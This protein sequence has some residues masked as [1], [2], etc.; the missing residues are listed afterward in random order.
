LALKQEVGFFLH[1]P[2]FLF[3]TLS[4]T[5]DQRA[6]SAWEWVMKWPG[7]VN[8]GV[9]F[10]MMPFVTLCGFSFQI[11]QKPTAGKHRAR[12][13]RLPWLARQSVTLNQ[14]KGVIIVCSD[15]ANTGTKQKKASVVG[16]K[17]NQLLKHVI[18]LAQLSGSS[19]M[20]HVMGR[21]S[22]GLANRKQ[23]RIAPIVT[24][25]LAAAA[26]SQSRTTGEQES[27]PSHGGF[28]WMVLTSCPG[29]SN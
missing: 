23:S 9:S 18:L 26:A 25:S 27:P 10:I 13:H 4:F 2:N 29:H 24:A 22:T 16:M 6:P 5:G 3:F 12:L 28:P 7:E 8:Q 15:C 14:G 21:D 1:S 11:Q 17:F 19:A 20:D